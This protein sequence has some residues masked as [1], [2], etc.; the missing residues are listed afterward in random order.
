MYRSLLVLHRAGKA[1]QPRQEVPPQHQPAAANRPEQ[2]AE[3]Q[4]ARLAWLDLGLSLAKPA[5]HKYM[6]NK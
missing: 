2:L 6:K 5:K 4:A 1:P 3:A